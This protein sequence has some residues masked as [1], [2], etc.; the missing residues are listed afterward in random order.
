MAISKKK[1]RY[2]LHTKKSN[3]N[4]TRSGLYQRVE[5]FYTGYIKEAC[6]ASN[7]AVAIEGELKW[8]VTFFVLE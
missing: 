8:Y 1:L 3:T 7:W 4:I 2:D 6:V 5:V